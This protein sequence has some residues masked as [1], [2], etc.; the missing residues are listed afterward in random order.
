MKHVY[1]KS[2]NIEIMLGDKQKKLFKNS[3]ILFYKNIKR[4]RR[5]NER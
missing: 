4:L 5:I 2:D 3:L 1:S